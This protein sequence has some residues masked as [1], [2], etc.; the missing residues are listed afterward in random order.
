M[1]ER[2][3]EVIETLDEKGSKIKYQL[4]IQRLRCETEAMSRVLVSHEKWLIGAEAAVY[5]PKEQNRV[6][7]QSKVSFIKR[8]DLL[9][10]VLKC[11]VL[12][13]AS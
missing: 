9:N 10:T 13:F 8:C 11:F 1:E 12:N 6:F 7:E 4:D 3:A 2:W 5:E